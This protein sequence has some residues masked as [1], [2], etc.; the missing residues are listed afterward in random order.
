MSVEQPAGGMEWT[1]GCAMNNS[2]MF[3]AQVRAD[4][5]GLR[6]VCLSGTLAPI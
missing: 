3:D 5:R 4:V 1:L 6:D 2:L